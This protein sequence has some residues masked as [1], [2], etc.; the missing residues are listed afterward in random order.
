M[1][2]KFIAL[3][4]IATS[5]FT[6]CKKDK[7]DATPLPIV[8]TNTFT[9][10]ENGSTT[11]NTADSVKFLYSESGGVAAYKNGR[12]AV[13][14]MLFFAKGAATYNLTNNIMTTEGHALQQ[15]AGFSANAGTITVSSLSTTGIAGTFD[16]S[17]PAAGN[18]SSMKGSFN[19]QKK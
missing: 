16:V 13:E 17:G 7:D 18:V 9:W 2:T 14:I 1:K 15:V 8:G 10:T 11:V 12:V 4:L 19:A 6:A 3:L 5:A